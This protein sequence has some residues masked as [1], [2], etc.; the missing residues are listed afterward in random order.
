[1]PFALFHSRFPEIAEAETR[2]ITVPADN[3]WKLPAASYGFLDMYCDEPGCDCR[4]VMLFVTSSARPPGRQ[5]QAVIGYGWEPADFYRTWFHDHASSEDIAEMMGPSLNFGSPQTDLAPALL[6]VFQQVV[7]PSQGY[8]ERLKHHYE[9][10]RA[11]VE[12]GVEAGKAR[13]KRS[14]KL[15]GLP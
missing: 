5:P 6:R 2:S 7:L 12:G 13:K 14:R 8:A 1:M 10:F 15:R 9:M 4:R 11:A 3:P